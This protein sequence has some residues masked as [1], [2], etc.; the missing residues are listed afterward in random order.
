MAIW[1]A[2]CEPR[3]LLTGHAGV[4][5]RS[6]SFR[7]PGEATY[8]IGCAAMCAVVRES[9][10]SMLQFRC[11]WSAGCC[12]V[13]IVPQN[14]KRIETPSREVPLA[15]TG[16][17]HSTG[18]DAVFSTTVICQTVATC[19]VQLHCQQCQEK[20]SGLV[21]RAITTRTLRSLHR[22]PQLLQCCECGLSATW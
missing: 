12:T 2:T 4:S 21:Y 5:E 7:A 10:G 11:F 19:L 8:R 14:R 17:M 22:H 13:V 20:A 6:L 1:A 9:A 16:V 3:G 15:C 18:T